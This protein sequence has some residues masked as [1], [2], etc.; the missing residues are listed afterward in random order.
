MLCERMI[1]LIERLQSEIELLRKR[2][3]EVEWST[4]FL[5]G[6]IEAGESEMMTHLEESEK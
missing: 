4:M 3:D 1:G 6:A 2:L 5:E